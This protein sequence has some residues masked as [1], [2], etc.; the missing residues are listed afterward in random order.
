LI[1]EGELDNKGGFDNERG[2]KATCLQMSQNIL[3][4]MN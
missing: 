1:I 3:R 4:K 2:F